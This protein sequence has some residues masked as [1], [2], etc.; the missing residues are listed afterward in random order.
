MT[1]SEVQDIHKV[2]VA[3][4]QHLDTKA[5]PL[6]NLRNITSRLNTS[7]SDFREKISELSG[8][9]LA[10]YARDAA[11]RLAKGDR[12]P[13]RK[14]GPQATGRVAKGTSPSKDDKG[15]ALKRSFSRPGS[16]PGPKRNDEPPQGP[17]ECY[18]HM[19]SMADY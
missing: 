15:N 17:W 16:K 7:D 9:A 2:A 11:E 10:D 14:A 1:L 5:S 3:L 6:R 13:R 12:E 18:A 4:R 19:T 8:D